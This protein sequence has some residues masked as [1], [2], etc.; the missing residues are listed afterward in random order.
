[1]ARAIRLAEEAIADNTD[2]A[3]EAVKAAVSEIARTNSKGII[4]RN[5]ASRQTSRL[6]S[7]LN[8]SRQK[9]TAEATS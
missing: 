7:K 1:M 8:A 9:D 2:N 4:H 5:K 3:E 6:M